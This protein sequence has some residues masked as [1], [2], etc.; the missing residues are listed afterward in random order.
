MSHRSQLESTFRHLPLTPVLITHTGGFKNTAVIKNH[1]SV[2]KNRKM[3]ALKSS[4]E[5]SPSDLAKL[6]IILAF[7][8]K[9]DYSALLVSK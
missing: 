7:Q 1:N 6:L 8:K 5:N 2:Y 3:E 9:L 4:K